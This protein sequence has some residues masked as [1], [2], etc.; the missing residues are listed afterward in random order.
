[1]YDVKK[2]GW[3]SD[4]TNEDLLRWSQEPANASQ[5][6]AQFIRASA[7]LEKNRRGGE[8]AEAVA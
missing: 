7:L 8:V 3:V 6:E 2:K 4:C 1:M 5:P